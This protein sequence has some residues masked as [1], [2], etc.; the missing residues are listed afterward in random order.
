MIRVMV[1]DDSAL[2]RRIATDILKEDPEITVVAT[3][4]QAEFALMKLDKEQPDVITLDMEMPG[5][6]GLEAI[7][8]IMAVRP[9]PIIVLSAHAQKGAELTLQALELGAV[10]FV[11]KPSSSLSGGI[12]S[13][14]QELVEK[15]KS[16]AKIVFRS[17]VAYTVAPQYPLAA[18]ARISV[19]AAGERAMGDYDLVAI[20]TSTGGPVALKTVLTMLPGDLPVGIVVVQHMPPVFTKAFAERLNSC[21]SLTVKEAMNGDAIIPGQVLLAPGNWHMTVSRFGSE[22]KVVL[23]QTENVNG[24]RPSVDVLMHSVALEYGNHA[25]GVI[26]TGMGRDG[27]DGLHELHNRGGYVIAQDKDSSVIYGMNRE[28]IQNG[29]AHEVAPVDVIAGRI[30]D[31]LRARATR[32]A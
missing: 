30:M 9:T 1:V 8:R 31:A 4:A 5:M 23:N 32:R 22:P 12:S 24:H 26:M 10:D 7:R 18:P 29:D 14:A 16:A 15:V 20:G 17:P 11:L 27:A 25:I 13:V 21:C 19:R 28:V 6:G 3:A 2:V